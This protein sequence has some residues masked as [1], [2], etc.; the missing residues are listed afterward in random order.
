LLEKIGPGE[1]TH[2]VPWSSL[3]P[4]QKSFQ[5]TKMSIHAA[6]ISRMDREI[7]RVLDQLK[8]MDAFRDTVILFISDNGA[9][10][11][12]LIRADG[13][14]ATAPPGGTA[15]PRARSR[16]RALS[17]YRRRASRQMPPNTA[18]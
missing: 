5:R 3:T 8:A 2:A 1:V 18:S 4:V 17:G 7:G 12:Q 11:E 10:S 16:H 15:H 9:S 13:H 14:D 6:M